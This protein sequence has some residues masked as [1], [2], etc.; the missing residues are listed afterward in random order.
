[1]DGTDAFDT[2][3]Q[4][5]QR[6]GVPASEENAAIAAYERLR[7]ARAIARSLLVKPNNADVLV[8]FSAL[9]AHSGT[10]KVP[11]AVE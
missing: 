8:V 2:R 10:R 4:A 3:L 1:M 11:R 6:A 9:M 5:M 7:T